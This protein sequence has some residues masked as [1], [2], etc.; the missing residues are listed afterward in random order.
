MLRHFVLTLTIAIALAPTIAYAVDVPET[1]VGT[2][3]PEGRC[4]AADGGPVSITSTTLQWA[5]EGVA[6]PAVWYE[7]DSPS[8]NGAIHL[9]EEGDVANFEYAADQ[10]VLLFNEQGY[11]MGVAAVPYVRCGS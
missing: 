3:A 8:G 2:W 5:G 11:G 4:D 1:L 7:N 9:G 6:A 10:D